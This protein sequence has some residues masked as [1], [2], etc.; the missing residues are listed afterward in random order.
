MFDQIEQVVMIQLER[1]SKWFG[2]YG[3]LYAIDLDI[4]R[5]ESVA[6]IGPNGAGKTTLL[7]ILAGLNKPSEGRVRVAGFDLAE[8]PEAARRSVGLI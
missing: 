6:L 2:D 3:A 1:V 8:A 5:G 7:R 4:A